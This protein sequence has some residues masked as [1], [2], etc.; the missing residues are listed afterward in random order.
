VI[1]FS[2]ENDGLEVIKSVSGSWQ[3]GEWQSEV[4]DVDLIIVAMSSPASQP[5]A[6]LARAS[7]AGRV[8]QVPLLL[9]SDRPFRSDSEG[10]IAHLDFP[11]E[12]DGLYDKVEKILLE[13]KKPGFQGPG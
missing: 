12:I 1:E 10:Q 5:A 13:E 9:I 4:A 6:V 7:V 11:F 2:L 8:G 3:Q